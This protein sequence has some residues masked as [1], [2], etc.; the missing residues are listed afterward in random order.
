MI[1]VETERLRLSTYEREEAEELYA[2]LGNPDTMQFWPRPFTQQQTLEWIDKNQLRYREN[3]FG[4]WSVRLKDS[5][6]LIG[7]A[8]IM[9]SDTDGTPELDLGYIIDARHW[10][11]GFGYEAALACLTYGIEQLK[12]T[13]IC[14]NMAADHAASRAVAEKL[15]MKLEKQFINTRNRD[16]LTCLYSKEIH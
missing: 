12:L 2:V 10:R 4:R 11:K 6:A 13:R 14:A 7:D 3:G 5:G 1:I 9:I 8:G 16:I 15:G